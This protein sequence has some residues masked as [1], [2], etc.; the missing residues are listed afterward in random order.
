MPGMTQRLL[1]KINTRKLASLKA[2][3][4]A[5]PEHLKR[6]QAR[7]KAQYEAALRFLDKQAKITKID[8]EYQIDELEGKL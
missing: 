3:L 5:L 8:L 2:E 4:A 6:E 1:N 7:A